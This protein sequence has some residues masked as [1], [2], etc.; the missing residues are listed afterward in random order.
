MREISNIHLKISIPFTQ[1][2]REATTKRA[3]EKGRRR[4][5]N[6]AIIGEA[7][8]WIKEGGGWMGRRRERERGR[9]G[10]GSE[11]RK[12]VLTLSVLLCRERNGE[13]DD[14]LIETRQ[15]K[16]EKLEE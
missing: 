15:R 3:T 1:E 6:S 16:E 13:R 5:K 8:V 2:G 12:E 4:Y 10:R 14:I 7:V 11:G 9:E